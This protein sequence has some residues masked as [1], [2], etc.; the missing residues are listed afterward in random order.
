MRKVNIA[1]LTFPISEAGNVPLSNL[2]NILCSLFNDIYIITGNEGNVSARE[3]SRIHTYKIEH[4]M[5]ANILSRIAKY[6]H[7]QL[8]IC[9]KLVKVTKNVNLWIFFTGGEGLVLPMIT[10][11]LMKRKVV[12]I[13][14]ACPAKIS[15][16]RKDPL[17][18]ALSRLTKTNYTLSNRITVYSERFIQEWHLEKYRR[19]ISI[20][21]EHFL[22]FDKFRMEKRLNERRDLVGYIGRLSEEKGTLNFVTAIPEIPKEQKQVNFLVGGDGKLRD[23][24][25]KYIDEGNLKG[26]VAVP[27]WI[28]HDALPNYLNELK[29]L[30]LPSYTEGL[31]NIMLEA[32]ACGTPVLATPVGAVPDVIR[33]GETGFIM[34]DNSPECIANNVIRALNHPSLEQI[35]KNAHTLV[36]KEFTYEK[37]VERFRDILAGLT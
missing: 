19:K 5:G 17:S 11:K 26:K 22:N 24:I 3:D 32:M 25:D 27:G 14:V 20:A 6:V 29:L 13:L 36:K 31:P 12:L 33:D 1:I 7:T 34:K 9:Y 4:E 15:E 21:H 16:A 18:K 8:R 28:P 30:V 23:K 37:E 35:V 10:A 2:A